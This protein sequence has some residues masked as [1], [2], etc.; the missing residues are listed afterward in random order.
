MERSI[1]EVTQRRQNIDSRVK[2]NA[3]SWKWLF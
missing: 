1:N 2:D 3:A